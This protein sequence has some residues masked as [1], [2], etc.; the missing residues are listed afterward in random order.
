M[1]DDADIWCFHKDEGVRWEH[2]PK[3]KVTATTD[4]SFS[5]ADTVDPP[6]SK[7][8]KTTDDSW[9][10]SG[11]LAWVSSDTTSLSELMELNV[12]VANE[13]QARYL[14]CDLNWQPL[15]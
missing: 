9:N 10:R 11:I 5:Q 15:T 13:I 8:A 12:T 6:K 2:A 4:S 7:R 3:A 14:R 1:L